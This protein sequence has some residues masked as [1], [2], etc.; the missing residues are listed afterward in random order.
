MQHVL[1]LASAPG[2]IQFSELAKVGKRQERFSCSRFR[3]FILEQEF[4]CCY[5]KR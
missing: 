5:C 1:E 4:W 3:Y 2:E